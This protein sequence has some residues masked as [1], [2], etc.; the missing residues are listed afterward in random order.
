MNLARTLMLA[1]TLLVAAGLIGCSRAPKTATPKGGTGM[2]VPAGM[3]GMSSAAPGP[4]QPR[5]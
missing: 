1:C 2:Q 4:A 3:P 5:R